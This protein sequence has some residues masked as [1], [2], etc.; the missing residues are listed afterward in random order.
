MNFLFFFPTFCSKSTHPAQLMSRAVRRAFGWVKLRSRR[1]SEG[2]KTV[3]IS[4]R[5]RWLISLT[6]RSPH[7]L[8]WAESSPRSLFRKFLHMHKFRSVAF[9][10]RRNSAPKRFVPWTDCGQ[11]ALKV[12]RNP[13]S[14]IFCTSVPDPSFGSPPLL[15]PD[16]GAYQSSATDV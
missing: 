9:F 3:S 15:N 1:W 14:E 8:S 11:L 10:P 6:P 13:I 12:S 5:S 7:V 2:G 16:R 4:I